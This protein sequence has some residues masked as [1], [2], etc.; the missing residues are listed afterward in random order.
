MKEEI[1][2]RID[3]LNYELKGKQESIDLLKG[4]LNN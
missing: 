2:K 4:R 1:T 3:A